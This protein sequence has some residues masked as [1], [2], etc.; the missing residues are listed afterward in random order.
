MT[1]LEVINLF[2][3][4]SG[5]K[6]HLKKYEIEIIRE[7]ANQ[8]KLDIDEMDKLEQ[9]IKEDIFFLEKDYVYNLLTEAKVTLVELSKKSKYPTTYLKQRIDNKICINN[10]PY[11]YDKDE[12][13]LF[14]KIVERQKF[15]KCVE[16]GIVKNNSDW[17]KYFN[18]DKLNA[19]HYARNSIKYQGKYKFIEHQKQ[20]WEVL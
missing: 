17:K 2:S 6:L 12:N 7:R 5:T 16:L 10:I 9:V 18:D 20:L 1:A 19:S 8:Y 15:F 11:Y 13:P 14:F 3:L 4:P